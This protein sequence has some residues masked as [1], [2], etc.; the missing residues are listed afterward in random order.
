MCCDSKAYIRDHHSL[1]DLNNTLEYGADS[2]LKILESVNNYLQGVK[3]ALLKQL[4]GLEEEL[5]IA[6]EELAEAERAHSSCI[7]SQHWVEEYEDEDGNTHGGYYTPSCDSEASEV[8]R[9]QKEH[10]RCQERYDKGKRICDE[11]DNEIAKYKETGGFVIPPGGERT[12]EYLAKDHTDKSTSKMRE[13][14][15]VV[16]EYLRCN[17]STKSYNTSSTLTDSNLND[18]ESDRPLSPTQKKERFTNAV[19]RVIQRQHAENYGSD[20]IAEAN[21]AIVCPYCGRP[22]VACICSNAREREYTREQ[23]N[24]INSNSFSR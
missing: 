4:K 23:I 5:R 8:E 10:D 21:R 18:S 2:I 22:L 1:I 15:A 20:K 3:E 24:I 16:E 19:Q 12:L 17:M 9:C 14:L 11:C 6:E 7:A 13:I